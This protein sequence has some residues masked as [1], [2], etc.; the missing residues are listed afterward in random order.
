MSTNTVPT[1]QAHLPS[2][3]A[4]ILKTLGFGRGLSKN[5]PTTEKATRLCL[6][7]KTIMNDPNQCNT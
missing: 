1:K 6:R 2:F 7:T 3:G 4:Q 5:P